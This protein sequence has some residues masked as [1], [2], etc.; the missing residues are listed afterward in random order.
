M[1]LEKQ[2]TI[3]DPLNRDCPLSSS[4]WV[5]KSTWDDSKCKCIYLDCGEYF[6]MY[7]LAQLGLKYIVTNGTIKDPVVPDKIDLNNLYYSLIRVKDMSDFEKDT[8]GE[9]IIKS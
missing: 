2:I 7:E 5:S 8:I 1:F 4:F 3:Y 9:L 6:I